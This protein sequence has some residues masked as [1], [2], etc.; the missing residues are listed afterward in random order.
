MIITNEISLVITVWLV[1]QYSNEVDAE[2]E[3]I[4]Y[5][6]SP[7][8]FEAAQ[9]FKSAVADNLKLSTSISQPSAAFELLDSRGALPYISISNMI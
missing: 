4:P 7:P 8:R 2:L 1:L 9:R 5:Y 3:Q 6:K